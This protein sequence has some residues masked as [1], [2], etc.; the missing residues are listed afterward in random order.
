M[1]LHVVSHP[2][3]E[4]ALASLR[5]RATPPDAFRRLARRV[6]L[7]LAAEATRDLPTVGAEVE[8]PLETTVTQRLSGRVV[9]VPILRAGQGMLDAFLE[10][11]P[12]AEVP[13]RVSTPV[14]GSKLPVIPS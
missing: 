4:H 8:T 14:A 9:A 3:V 11:V 6:S 5:D 7:V 10:L 12:T 2:V 1:Q 13:V